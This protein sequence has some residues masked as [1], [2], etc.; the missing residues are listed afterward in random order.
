MQPKK[1]QQSRPVGHYSSRHQFTNKIGFKINKK[2]S[3][4]IFYWHKFRT[5]NRSL[6][7]N[8]RI[9]DICNKYFKY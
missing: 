5:Y 1:K 3:S 7:A 2:S 8:G 6:I 9:D 4:R